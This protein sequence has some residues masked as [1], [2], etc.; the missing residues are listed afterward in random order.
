M[1]DKNEKDAA[2]AD[3]V[4][5]HDKLVKKHTDEIASLVYELSKLG[6]SSSGMQ[7]IETASTK[8]NTQAGP[9]LGEV[10]E[11]IRANEEAIAELKK[12]AGD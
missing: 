8:P 10:L 9:G 7:S 6:R 12:N 4:A 2:I 5:H 11:R 1:Q 3:K